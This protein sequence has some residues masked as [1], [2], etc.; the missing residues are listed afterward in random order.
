MAIGDA[1][2][3]A[4]EYRDRAEKS[5]T[6][7]DTAISSELKAVA[8]YIDR[9][10]VRPLGFNKDATAVARYYTP[11]KSCQSL[12]IDDHVSISA[13]AI[14]TGLDNTFATSLSVSDWLAYPRNAANLP[15]PQPYRRIDATV[16]GSFG[17][18]TAGVAVRVTGIGG[19]PAVPEAIKSANIE[20]TRIL[21]L[22]SDRAT[23]RVNEVGQVLSVSRLARD[24]V[25]DLVATYRLKRTLL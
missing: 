16:W 11:P 5:S 2:A 15:E 18:F 24:I 19:W 17:M 9:V 4:A 23:Q 22:E 10:T 8:R 3:T 1:Y 21:R 25:A 20:M 14:D 13:I 7:D 6:A 12:D